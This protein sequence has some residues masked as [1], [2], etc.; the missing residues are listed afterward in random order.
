MPALCDATRPYGVGKCKARRVRGAD[1]ATVHAWN[2]TLALECASGGPCFCIAVSN[3]RPDLSTYDALCPR[4]AHR[5]GVSLWPRVGIRVR[6]GAHG[7]LMREGLSEFAQRTKRRMLAA[8]HAA[9]VRQQYGLALVVVVQEDEEVVVA[10]LVVEGRRHLPAPHP[11]PRPCH[12]ARARIA[13][14]R[15]GTAGS[16]EGP[17]V[18]RGANIRTIQ[19]RRPS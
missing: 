16:L 7:V 1:V 19:L 5:A 17:G 13:S 14:S 4:D 18:L 2:C 6:Q 11:C 9:H 15:V 12:T 10:R 8:Q 3:V